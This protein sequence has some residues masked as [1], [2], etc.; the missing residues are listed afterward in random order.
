MEAIEK[1]MLF[2]KSKPLIRFPRGHAVALTVLAIALT[3]FS[4]APL[5]TNSYSQRVVT[6]I[7]LPITPLDDL[8]L[9][10][11]FLISPAEEAQPDI[12]NNELRSVTIKSGDNLS[13][14]FKR[15]EL[16][17]RDMLA[18]L[19]GSKDSKRLTTLFPGHIVNFSISP[20]QG[21]EKLTYVIDRL[22][23]FSFIKNGDQ[24]DYLEHVRTPDIHTAQSSGVINQSLYTAGIAA[25]LDDKLIMELADIF[26]WDIDFAL[27]IRKGD[28]FKVIY[29]E[30]FLDGEKIGN[31]SILAAEFVN[32]GERY[33]AIRYTNTRGETGYFTP[34]GQS[35]R[36]EFLRAPLDFRR[37][38]SNFNPRRLHP[39][40]KTV[41]PHRGIDYAA[42]TG[43]PIWSS[44]SGSVIASGYTATNGNYVVIQHGNGVQ[45]KY[46]HLKKRLVKKG[47]KVKQ[48]QTIGLLGAT[49]LATGP[50]LHYEFL[51]NG[52]HR[53]P[54]TILNHMPKARSISTTELPRFIVE[55]RDQIALLKDNTSS[56][57][58]ATNDQQETTKR[59]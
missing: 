28:Q 25:R 16:N 4:L 55:T 9:T 49:G 7:D 12:A 21:L 10:Q 56:T 50:H 39:V 1:L 2:I 35:L 26:G 22:N 13:V 43:T 30:K 58:F 11:D 59:L 48:K 41:R 8:D 24:F 32:Q 15:A 52:V 34:E 36:K 33:Q 57:Q 45:T 29:E 40:T 17:D 42:P 38:S 27:D 31:G 18:V 37:I 3:G 44:G 46:L 19:N 23:S 47:Q 14:V 5:E 6:Q 53:N 54:R 51:V 20:E